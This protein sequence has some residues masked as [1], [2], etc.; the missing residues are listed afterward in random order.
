MRGCG[1]VRCKKKREKDFFFRRSKFLIFAL[2][3]KKK[4]FD[5]L[6][7]P[8]PPGSFGAQ[9]LASRSKPARFLFGSEERARKVREEVEKQGS[10]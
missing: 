10:E 6:P 1:E 3:K 5:A 9:A 8:R 7:F 2:S 4:A